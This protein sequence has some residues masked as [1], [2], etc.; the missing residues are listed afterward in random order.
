MPALIVG[1]VTVSVANAAQP[2]DA[3]PVGGEIVRMFDGSARTTVRSYKRTW[4]ITTTLLTT[5]AA[6][7]LRTALVTTTLP[8]AC[9]GD[10]TGAVNCIPRLT[11]YEAVAAR[12]VVR[13]RV[14]FT[15]VE[16]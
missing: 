5:S 1:G 4:S 15:L 8:V 16:V 10:I 13:R 14:S 11:G 7:T 3:E 6:A 12:G 9:S 2:E